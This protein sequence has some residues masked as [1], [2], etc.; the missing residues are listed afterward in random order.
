MNERLERLYEAL[1]DAIDNGEMTEAEAAAEFR[2]AKEDM[3]REINDRYWGED[4]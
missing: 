4:R 1:Q 2:C 3:W